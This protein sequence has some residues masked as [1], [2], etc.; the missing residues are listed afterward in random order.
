MSQSVA[1][2][3]YIGARGQALQPHAHGAETATMQPRKGAA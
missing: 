1:V 3:P 2:V